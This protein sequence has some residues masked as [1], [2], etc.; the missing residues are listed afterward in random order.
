MSKLQ[1]ET[2]S[3]TNNTTAQTIDSSGRVLTPA[4]PFV[5]FQSSGTGNVSVGNFETMGATDDGQSAFNTTSGTYGIG[6]TGISYNSA[7]GIFTLP[8]SGLYYASFHGYKN[9]GSASTARFYIKLVGSYIALGH[10]Q[11]EY[12]TIE[13]HHVFQASANDTL[14]FVHASGSDRTFYS[15][16]YHEFGSI[17]FIG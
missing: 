10:A 13:V 11:N 3:H 8:V 4:R 16:P 9:D 5:S 15:H 7:T 17:Y 12:G 2:I 6:I 1:V 14:S